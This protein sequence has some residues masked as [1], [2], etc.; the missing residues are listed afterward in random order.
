MM[1]LQGTV[2]TNGQ[3]SLLGS[4]EAPPDPDWGWKIIIDVPGADKISIG[5]YNITPDGVKELAVQ[6]DYVRAAN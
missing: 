4:Y 5:M 6:A 3:I 1:A 2:D